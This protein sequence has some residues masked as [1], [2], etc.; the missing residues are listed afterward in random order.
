MAPPDPVRA[1]TEACR[2]PDGPED[3]VVAVKVCLLCR[4]LCTCCLLL[5]HAESFYPEMSQTNI[6]LPLSCN[7]VGLLPLCCPT[8]T[9]VGKA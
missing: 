8:W 6:F 3:G 9:P 7:Q 5:L 2:S 1:A 4:S